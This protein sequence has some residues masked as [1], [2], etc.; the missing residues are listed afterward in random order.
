ML[1]TLF[2]S[3]L[4]FSLSVS[5]SRAQNHLSAYAEIS[6]LTCDA[7]NELYSTFGHS[8]IRIKDPSIQVDLIF[9]YGTFDFETPNF[10]LKFTR[11]KL[12]YMMSI[13][14]YRHYIQSYK[15]V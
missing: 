7:G 14:P 3:L 15:R 5:H 10:Y 4:A 1:R 13:S 8:A 11:G 2:I 9:N 6:I 12:D